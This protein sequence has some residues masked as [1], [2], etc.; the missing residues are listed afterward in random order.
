MPA[1]GQSF[2]F[3][4]PELARLATEAKSMAG[5]SAD[6]QE[7]H[8]DFSPAIM[9]NGNKA[10]HQLT[11]TIKSYTDP[12]SLNDNAG[13][14]TDLYNLVTKKAVCEKTKKDLVQQSKIGQKLFS[15]FVDER[16][17]S[18]KINLWAAM[19]KRKLQTWKSNGKVIKVKTVERVVELKEDRSLLLS[20]A[21]CTCSAQRGIIMVRLSFRISDC[22]RQ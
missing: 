15:S 2:F 14:N 11:Q 17:K 1:H 18:G 4:A 5:L 9:T 12:F 7:R 22:S 13:S 21:T 3:I 20:F 8:H 19:K 6:S 16:V 10:I